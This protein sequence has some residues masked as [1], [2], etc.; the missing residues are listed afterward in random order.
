MATQAIKKER[1]IELFAMVKF[2]TDR[3]FTL[4]IECILK[5]SGRK[6]RKQWKAKGF[7]T[8]SVEYFDCIVPVYQQF[9]VLLYLEVGLI[10]EDYV[11]TQILVVSLYFLK[12]VIDFLLPFGNICRLSCIKFP[13]RCYYTL[14][15]LIL[16]GQYR[17]I[18]D[19]NYATMF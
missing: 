18:Y 8:Q 19:K 5:T 17:K 4:I 6:R 16:I 1:K 9:K 3:V 13:Y 10:W 11:C 15:C 2:E 7:E 14:T 12:W